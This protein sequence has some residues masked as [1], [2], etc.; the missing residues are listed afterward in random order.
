MR[1][2]LTNT[3]GYISITYTYIVNTMCYSEEKHKIFMYDEKD[4]LLGW[5]ITDEWQTISFI[6]DNGQE[7]FIKGR[8]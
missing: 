6:D 7:H 2:L 4:E 1:I 3:C 5:L 8:K